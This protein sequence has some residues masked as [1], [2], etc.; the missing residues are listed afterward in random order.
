MHNEIILC[1][2]A[3]VL[4]LR[5]GSQDGILV[6]LKFIA[7]NSKHVALLTRLKLW[8]H[9]QMHNF[10]IYILLPFFS[11]YMFRRCR[12]PQGTTTT[13]YYNHHHHHFLKETTFSVKNLSDKASIFVPHRCL[14]LSRNKQREDRISMYVYVSVP[15]FTYSFVIAIKPKAKTQGLSLIEP[16]A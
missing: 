8:Y 13:Y 3:S 16:C 11:S 4:D 6:Q 2:W 12:H 1:S 10:A 15:S 14:Y 7:R 9:Q 5:P